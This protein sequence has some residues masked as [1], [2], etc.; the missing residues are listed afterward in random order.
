MI[1]RRSAIQLTASA[2]AVAAITPTSLL[3]DNDVGGTYPHRLP[4]LP[5]AKDALEPHIDA[6]TMDLHHGKHHKTYVDKL[7]EALADYPALHNQSVEELLR[8]IDQLPEKV[9]GA[10]RNHG[11]GHFNHSLFWLTL[12]P[13]GSGGKVSEPLKSAFG[14]LGATAEEIRELFLKVATGVFGSGWAWI[15]VTRS[16]QLKIE[17][18]P[19]QDVP[20]GPDKSP[21]LGLDVWEH[22]YYLKYQNRRADYVTAHGKVVNWNFV[23]ERFAKLTK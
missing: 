5:Y 19:N 7:N 13:A 22:A 15:T 10:V 8:G 20:F 16:G 11:G 23:N 14:E 4:T 17:S 1:S 6:Q 18:S 9:R 3:A 21:L 12:A 2:V